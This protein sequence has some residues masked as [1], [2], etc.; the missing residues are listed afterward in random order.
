MTII[1]DEQPLSKTVGIGGV[2]GKRQR[3]NAQRVSINA[4]SNS[5]DCEEGRSLLVTQPSAKPT[6][7]AG[8]T[9]ASAVPGHRRLVVIDA[10][11]V[12]G[13]FIILLVPK[14]REKEH[15]FWQEARVEVKAQS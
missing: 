13:C 2:S 1:L 11:R 3:F 8:S 10:M 4:I 9:I 12:V 14:F 6:K 5:E 15:H 7:N